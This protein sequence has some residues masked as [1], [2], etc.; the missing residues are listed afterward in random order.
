V[1]TLDDRVGSRELLQ[2]FPK[3]L[4]TLNR[5]EY[6]DACFIGN[7]PNNEPWNIGI[8]RKGLRDLLNSMVTGRLSGHQLIGLLNSYDVV[9]LVVE[10]L[11]RGDPVNGILQYRQGKHWTSVS[12]GSRQFMK[13]DL[14]GFVNTLMVMGAVLVRETMSSRETASLITNLYHWWSKPWEDHKSHVSLHKSRYRS[15]IMPVKPSVLRSVASE[16]PGVGWELSGR[17]EKHF[18]NILEM[19]LADVSDWVQIKGIGKRTAQKVV[20]E[21]KGGE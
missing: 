12:L 15:S 7:G 10:G 13:R 5:L 18:S 14:D 8:E 4:A 1:I 6:A 19:A 21:I 17:V 20:E 3:G 2:Y 11:W 9:Y 16:L